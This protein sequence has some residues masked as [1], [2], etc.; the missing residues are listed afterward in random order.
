[1]VAAKGHEHAQEYAPGRHGLFT[2]ALLEGLRGA[3]DDDGDRRVTLA[4]AFRFAVPA[5]ERLR[6]RAVGTQTPQLVAPEPL[7]ATA[8]ARVPAG[9]RGS[10]AGSR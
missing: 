5:V 8:L 10:W 7:G 6:D 1:M 4:E 2:F 3:A 9:V